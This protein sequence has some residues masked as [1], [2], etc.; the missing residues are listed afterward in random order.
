MSLAK[1]ILVRSRAVD[2]LIATS[3]RQVRVLMYHE[4]SPHGLSPELFD[5]HLRYIGSRF[6]CYWAGEIPSLLDRRT[7]RRR[8][9]AVLTFDDG[10]RN[11][12]DY[13]VPLLERR[14]IK[15]TFFLV[16]DL[17]LETGQSMLWNHEMLCRLLVSDPAALPSEIGPLD[18]APAIR[19]PQAR[20]FI[21]SMKGWPE[22]RRAELLATLRE[23]EPSPAYEPWMLEKYL[24]MS[25]R[26]IAQLPMSIE[27]GSHTRTHAILPTLDDARA[28]DEIAGSRR[29]LE[30]LVG[31]PVTSFCYPN[32]EF[33]DRDLRITR[34]SYET[35]VT[36][37]ERLADRRDDRHR[38]PRVP[39]AYNTRDLA[40]RMIRPG[41][42]EASPDPV[43][44]LARSAAGDQ[45]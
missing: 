2:L 36:V 16:S 6:D 5:Q 30:D 13:A 3:R 41:A 37:E 15:A 42:G 45:P 14:G 34:D 24:I 31:R 38:L 33:S 17:L 23:H 22:P 9:A 29:V 43:A 21:E 39:A 26:D 28:R 10:L 11:N 12:L 19:F 8:P 25:R 27:I 7:A 20:R 4:V 40:I 32:G 35:A 18:P 1:D 44:A